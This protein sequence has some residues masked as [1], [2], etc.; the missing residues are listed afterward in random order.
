MAVI[1]RETIIGVN[2][3]IPDVLVNTKGNT[4]PVKA[5]EFTTLS[6]LYES[7]KILLEDTHGRIS[8]ESLPPKPTQRILE[9]EAKDFWDTVC[10]KVDLFREALHDSNETG[11]DR[12]RELRRDYV[13][14]KPV[15]QWALIE[16]IVRL[17]NEDGETGSRVSLE[18]A[19]RRANKLEWG[20]SDPRWQLVLMNGER[21]LSGRTAVKFAAQVIEY[22]LGGDLPAAQLEELQDRYKRQG[23]TKELADPIQLP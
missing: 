10:S 8:T 22:W 19:C 17:R 4:L 9:E 23:A 2:N 21:V 13:I 6:I 18:E 20:V 14:G 1:V 12:R 7:T 16:A 3:T 5:S 15:G 11:D